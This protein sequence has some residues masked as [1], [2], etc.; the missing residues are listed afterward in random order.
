MNGV[1]IIGLM[2]V[3]ILGLAIGREYFATKKDGYIKR[4]FDEHDH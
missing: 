4:K 3:I 1:V 2:L